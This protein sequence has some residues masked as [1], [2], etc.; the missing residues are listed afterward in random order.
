MTEKT[1]IICDIDGVLADC[2]HRLKYISGEEKD[3]E[4]FYGISMARDTLIESGQEL[5]NRLRKEHYSYEEHELLLL[6]GRPE[7]TAEI[8][9]NWLIAN[10]VC[11]HFT[12]MLMRKDGDFRPSP[13]VKVE[14][15]ESL[16]RGIK[17]RKL[18]KKLKSAWKD[19][20]IEKYDHI[21][22]I[23]DDSKNVKAVCEAFPEVVGITFGIG[24]L[25]D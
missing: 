18:S 16:L 2:T 3:Y 6:T 15:L 24:R 25:N 23:D 22:F 5:I 21:W 4:S 17:P 1:L 11:G 8:T 9:R 7:R 14:L 12:K 20:A 13:E 10:G 19:A